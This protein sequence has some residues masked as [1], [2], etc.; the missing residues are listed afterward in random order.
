MTEIIGGM[1]RFKFLLQ[2]KRISKSRQ[3]A[4]LNCKRFRQ[5]KLNFE[6][7]LKTV[8]KLVYYPKFLEIPNAQFRSVAGFGV[9]S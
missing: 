9:V 8:I 2:Q 7:S 6:I 1:F 3:S 4:L 5:I